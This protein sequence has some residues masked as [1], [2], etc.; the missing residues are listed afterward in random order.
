MPP[1]PVGKDL[2]PKVQLKEF[3]NIKDAGQFR[4]MWNKIKEIKFN[5]YTEIEYE[6]FEQ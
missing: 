4:Q 2:V 1:F 5:S 6:I 3:G